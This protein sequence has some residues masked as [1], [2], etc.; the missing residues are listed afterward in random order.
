[1]H[2]CLLHKMPLIKYCAEVNVISTVNKDG[3]SHFILFSNVGVDLL[4]RSYLHIRES[5][6]RLQITCRTTAHH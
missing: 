3:G 6:L 5:Q 2:I 4:E 1:M